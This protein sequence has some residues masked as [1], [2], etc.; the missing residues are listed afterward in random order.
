MATTSR[1]AIAA[2]RLDEDPDLPGDVF[3]F[4]T[5]PIKTKGEFPLRAVRWKK[6]DPAPG[7]IE[8]EGWGNFSGNGLVVLWDGDVVATSY[9]ATATAWS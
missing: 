1:D 9:P 7:V 3:V 2:Q 8:A 4:L 5:W 6:I